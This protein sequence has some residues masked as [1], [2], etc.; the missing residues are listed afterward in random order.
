M[1]KG[2]FKNNIYIE[3]QMT[4][5]SQLITGR[6]I[7]PV[8]G[9]TTVNFGIVLAKAEEHK[10]KWLEHSGRRESCVIRGEQCYIAYHFVRQGKRFF[11]CVIYVFCLLVFDNS[12][13]N[14][15]SPE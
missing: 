14:W 8:A 3:F 13:C 1:G 6:R 11:V 4:R 5:E 7:L 12:K 9:M 10:G 2:L 15:E